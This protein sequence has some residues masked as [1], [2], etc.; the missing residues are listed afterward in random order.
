M[1]ENNN[2]I[3]LGLEGV[4]V[5]DLD[6]VRSTEINEYTEKRLAL[7]QELDIGNV[8]GYG[9]K[10]LEAKSA[11]MRMLSTK[12]GMYAK[13]PIT[14]KSDQCPY[15]ENCKILA[16]D[17]APEGELC[18]IETTEIEIRYEQYCSDFGFDSASFTDRVLM[19][20]I[21]SCD[22]MLERCKAMM[23]KEGDP[24]IDVVAGVSERGAEYTQPQVSKYWEAYERISKKRNNDLQLMMATRR[25]KKDDDAGAKAKNISEILAQVAQEDMAL[26]KK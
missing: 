6:E 4:L 16:Y 9:T 14:C 1:A 21:I 24:V 5:S 19:S 23:A 8:W 26:E 20:E 3:D 18:P 2:D 10:G 11:A 25:D 17:M 13:I 7:E 12:T 15:S 22:I